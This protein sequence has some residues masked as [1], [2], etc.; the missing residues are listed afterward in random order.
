MTVKPPSQRQ[1]RVG[2]EIRHALARILMNADFR[3]PALVGRVI[4]VS[5]VRL[6]PDLRAA[7]AFVTP[8]GGEELDDVVTALKRAA[9]YLRGLLAREVTLRTVPR[10]SFEADRS[11]EEAARINRLLKG[12]KAAHDLANREAGDDAPDP[13]ENRDDGA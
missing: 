5:E 9:P 8:L 13:E 3:D 1:L 4:T 7:T 11:F 2:E 6:S 12:G 10:L